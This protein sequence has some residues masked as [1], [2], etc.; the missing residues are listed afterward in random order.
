MRKIILIAFL[1]CLPFT[2]MASVIISRTCQ[3]L[4]P[5]SAPAKPAPELPLNALTYFLQ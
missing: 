4:E 5:A 1:S 2:Q 3:V